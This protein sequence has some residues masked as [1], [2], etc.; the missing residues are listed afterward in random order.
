M[1]AI[2]HSDGGARVPGAAWWPMR[3]TPA[4]GFRGGS[5]LVS[6]GHTTEADRPVAHRFIQNFGAVVDDFGN[7]VRVAS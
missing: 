2:Q 7:L 4:L 3:S 6:L 5:W 1:D